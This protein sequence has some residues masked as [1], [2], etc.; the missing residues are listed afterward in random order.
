LALWAVAHKEPLPASLEELV[1]RLTF[2]A[3]GGTEANSIVEEGHQYLNKLD[4]AHSKAT[5]ELRCHAE[6]RN[7][8]Q[9]EKLALKTQPQNVDKRQMILKRMHVLP[10]HMQESSV[11]R[12]QNS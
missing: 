11:A 8:V 2:S 10:G 9:V 6:E 7:G 12:R 4:A 3:A 1:F 5:T